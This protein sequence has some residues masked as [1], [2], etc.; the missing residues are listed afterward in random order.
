MSIFKERKLQEEDAAGVDR[1]RYAM[2][3]DLAHSKSDI[4]TEKCT[5]NLSNLKNKIDKLNVDKLVPA[6]VDL[7]EL[8]DVIKKD[9]VKKM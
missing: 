2:K 7:S 6:L 5:I 8:N 4:E 1:S 3:V 9:V